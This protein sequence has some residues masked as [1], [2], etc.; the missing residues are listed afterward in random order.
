M[1]TFLVLQVPLMAGWRAMGKRLR[2]MTDKGIHMGNLTMHCGKD[3]LM[4]GNSIPN[5]PCSFF[6]SPCPP[7]SGGDALGQGSIL[8]YVVLSLQTLAV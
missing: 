2:D 3:V 4:C 5:H 7:L 1:E 8:C 6:S